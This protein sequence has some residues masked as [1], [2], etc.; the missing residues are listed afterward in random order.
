MKTAKNLVTEVVVQTDWVSDNRM[1]KFYKLLNIPSL[2]LTGRKADT[3]GAIGNR[4]LVPLPSFDK[5][6][7]DTTNVIIENGKDREE[8]IRKYMKDFNPHNKFA[9]AIDIHSGSKVLLELYSD[10]N[11]KE[12]VYLTRLPESV[13]PSR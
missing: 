9:D 10:D 6:N 1:S 12:K 2:L 7:N 5:L 4:Y 13:S 11:N 3:R 8:T